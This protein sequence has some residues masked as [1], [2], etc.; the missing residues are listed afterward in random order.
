M[1]SPTLTLFF[2]STLSY[3]F[4]TYFNN[5]IMEAVWQRDRLSG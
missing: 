5:N 4:V 1:W 3:K 2:S